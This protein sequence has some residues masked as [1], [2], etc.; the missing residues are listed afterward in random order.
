M[1]ECIITGILSLC[2]T[3]A[4]AYAAHRTSSKLLAY[5]ME[6]LEK[7]VELHNNAIERLYKV[8]KTLDVHEAKMADANRRLEDIETQNNHQGG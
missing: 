7:K 8:E 4:G 1:T 2:G 5:R 3:L 6:Q